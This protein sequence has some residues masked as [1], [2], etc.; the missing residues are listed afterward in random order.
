MALSAVLFD[1]DGLLVDTEPAW[2]RAERTLVGEL[3]GRSWG[4]DDQRAILGLSLPLAIG[5]IQQR[6]GSPASQEA[7][8]DRLVD[9]F[10]A[11]LGGGRIP[12]QP[13]AAELV[14]EVAEACVPFALVSASV[15]RIMSM[16]MAHMSAHGLPTFPVSI[17]GD[18]VPRGK[19]DPMPYLQAAALLGVP[20]GSAVVLEDSP[21]G[22]QA[23]WAAGATV[24]AVEA[25]VRHHPRDRVVV[26]PSLAGLRLAD[27]RALAD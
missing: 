22:V 21:N 5:Y 6:T 18:E 12:M 13:G 27:L 24:V 11:E 8:G 2:M 10:L 20:I 19:P 16:V 14:T 3:G 7:I 25:M 1:M 9:L 15:R 17:A 23:G 26:R 4:E